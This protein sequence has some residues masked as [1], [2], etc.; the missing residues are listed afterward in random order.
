MLRAEVQLEIDVLSTSDLAA[1]RLDSV[2]RVL[3]LERDRLLI[4][5]LVN[6]PM[7]WHED[8]R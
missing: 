2:M 5:L 3:G 6:G 8:W 1:G 7:E 4:L